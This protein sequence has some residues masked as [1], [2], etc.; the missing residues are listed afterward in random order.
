MYRNFTP[1]ILKTKYI[2]NTKYIQE[3]DALWDA[4]DDAFGAPSAELNK[5]QIDLNILVADLEKQSILTALQE[6]AYN[7]TKAARMLNVGRTAL[8]AK[9]KKYQLDR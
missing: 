6:C 4:L 8:I 3:Q 9:M 1:H 2:M 5:F 7:Q